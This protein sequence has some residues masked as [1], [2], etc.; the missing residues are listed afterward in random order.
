MAATTP[1]PYIAIPTSQ[2]AVSVSILDTT[3][4]IAGDKT[5]SYLTPPIKGHED[6]AVPCISFLVRHKPSGRSLLFDLGIRRDWHNLSPS[7][8]DMIKEEGFTI[9]VAKD[10]PQILQEGGVDPDTIE[11]IIWSHHHFDHVGDPSLFGPSTALVVGPGFCDAF[12][13]GYPADPDGEIL[14]SDYAGREVREINFTAGVPGTLTIGR[15]RAFDYF[16]DGS[17][18]LLDVP[19]HDVGHLGGLA[20]VTTAPAASF[21]LMG[22]DAA[23]HGGEM[24]PTAYLP[25]PGQ[26]VPH[27]FW[28]CSGSPC[29]GHV[30]EPLL[31]RRVEEGGWRGKDW[32]TTPFYTASADAAH[33]DVEEQIRT[34]SKLQELDARDDV[35]VVLAHDQS[36][37]G[38]VDFFPAGTADRFVEK[39]W[40]ERARWGFLRDFAEA[41]GMLDVE[42][43]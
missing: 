8:V 7:I 35:F 42:T 3:S 10:V 21:V 39:G 16:G 30:F 18:Y 25:L 34:V 28:P 23:N 19:G 17:F 32:R 41:V 24:R 14:E 36:L 13:P 31:R 27:P 11:A 29:P 40:V 5:S 9:T 20:R 15:F 6:L 4:S 33:E 38:V 12:M 22:A 1:A 37:F 2:S 43:K 26:I